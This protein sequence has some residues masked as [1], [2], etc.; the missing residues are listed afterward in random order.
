MLFRSSNERIA[1]KKVFAHRMTIVNDNERKFQLK[2]DYRLFIL[3]MTHQLRTV[4]FTFVLQILV[5]P[6]AFVGLPMP[7]AECT[8]QLTV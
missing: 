2:S 3:L 1:D 4:A 7:E 8:L 6:S 5:N